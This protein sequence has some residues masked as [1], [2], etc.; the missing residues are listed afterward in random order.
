MARIADTSARPRV[1]DPGV[2]RNAV[3]QT[4]VQTAFKAKPVASVAGMDLLQVRDLMTQ[5][6]RSQGGRPSL[7]DAQDRV[8]LP[9]IADDWAVIE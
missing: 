1:I 6:L 3:A 2:K 7:V 9:K 5:M 4:F 8:K